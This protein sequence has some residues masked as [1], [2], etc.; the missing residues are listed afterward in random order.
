MTVPSQQ[1][2]KPIGNENSAGLESGT[3]EPSPSGPGHTA[4][5]SAIRISDAARP[6]STPTT[7]PV[8]LKRGQNSAHSSAGRLA[9]AATAKASPTRIDTL[10]PSPAAI[11]TPMAS[12]PRPIAATRA[13]RTSSRSSA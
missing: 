9:L 2:R 5:L 11:A 13:T 8:V 10:K 1:H 12:I 3:G 7:A 6:P 4:G